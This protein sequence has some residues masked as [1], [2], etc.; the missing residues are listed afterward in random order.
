MAAEASESDDGSDG[1]QRTVQVVEFTLDDERFAIDVGDVDSIVEPEGETRVPRTSAAIDGVMDLRG[2]ITA[3]LDPR[4]YL[5]VDDPRTDDQQ[6]LVIDQSIDKQ[7]LGLRVDQV[8]GVEEYG[9]DVVDDPN[10]F[11]EL[12]STGIR[13]KT[14]HSIIRKPTAESEFEPV[15]RLDI[16]AIIDQSRQA[17]VV[18]SGE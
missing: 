4:V 6:V 8:V 11:E 14:I 5:D 13:E 1:P 17:I 2:E 7:K 15:A 9:V 16:G 18:P 3:V 12:D 10:A